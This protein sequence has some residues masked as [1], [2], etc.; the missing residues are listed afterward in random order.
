MKEDQENQDKEIEAMKSP[1]KNLSLE[2]FI[3]SSTIVQYFAKKL[4]SYLSDK[5]HIVRKNALELGM[6]QI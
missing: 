4:N 2:D 6:I 3:N 5:T 1:K